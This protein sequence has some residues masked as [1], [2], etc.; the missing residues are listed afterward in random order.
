MMNMQTQNNQQRWLKEAEEVAE[1]A[2][3]QPSFKPGR[4][5]CTVEHTDEC[6]APTDLNH[7]VCGGKVTLR[8]GDA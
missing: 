8:E 1:A 2:M 6:Q 7:C 5:H 4:Y 3:R